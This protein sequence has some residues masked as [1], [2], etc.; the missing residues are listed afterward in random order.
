M[1]ALQ[2]KLAKELLADPAARAELQRFL[3]NKQPTTQDKPR[4]AATGQ[5]VIRHGN[6]SVSVKVVPKAA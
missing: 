6:S 1:K 2:S 3:T 5:F 4:N